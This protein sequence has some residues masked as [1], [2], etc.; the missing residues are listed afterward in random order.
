MRSSREIQ[1]VTGYTVDVSPSAWNQLATL[2][3]DDY[4]HIRAKLDAI[5]AELTA[6]Q[7]PQSPTQQPQGRSADARA[8]VLTGYAVLYAVDA[9]RGRV[10]L[11]EVAK[12]I[13]QE[14]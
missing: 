9:E 13:Q 10:T 1:P 4:G 14:E 6:A 5:A 8:F 3:T 12:R 7:P 2:A 11:L